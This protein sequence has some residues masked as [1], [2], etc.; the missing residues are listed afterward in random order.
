MS[1]LATIERMLLAKEQIK[2][3]EAVEDAAKAE[4]CAIL[5]DAEYGLIQDQ[6]VCTW[7]TTQR[8]SFD[9]KK[10]QKEHPALYEKFLKTTPVRTFR[11]SK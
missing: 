9:T 2:S 5:G 7:K 11:V 1:A 3:A 4:L 10:F 6:L 8:E